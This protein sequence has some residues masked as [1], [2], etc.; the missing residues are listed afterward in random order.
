M[1]APPPSPFTE[2]ADNETYYMCVYRKKRIHTHVHAQ[3]HT[4][5]VAETYQ[6]QGQLEGGYNI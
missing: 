3:S 5:T 1:Y 6:I 2:N 4:V